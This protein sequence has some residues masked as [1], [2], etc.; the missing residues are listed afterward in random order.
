MDGININS[1]EVSGTHS[2]LLGVL[3]GFALAGLFLLIGRIQKTNK[4]TE[5]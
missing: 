2:A 1:V 5:E 3:A 4:K